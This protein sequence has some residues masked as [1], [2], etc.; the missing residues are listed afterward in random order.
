MID[1]DGDQVGFVRFS[2]TGEDIRV[3]GQITLPQL[4]DGNRGFHIHETGRCDPPDFESADG[5][6][7]P[8]GAPHGGPDDP[9]EER[10]A[11]DLGNVEFGPGGEAEI[12]LVAP[13]LRLDEIIGLAVLVHEEED[14]LTT[15]PTGD[16][17]D[18]AACGVIRP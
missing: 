5:H 10:H 8:H 15:D 6:Y 12:D 11:G 17:G 14:D 13:G 16:S 9:P 3:Q 1:S 4:A 18:R 7:D 2:P